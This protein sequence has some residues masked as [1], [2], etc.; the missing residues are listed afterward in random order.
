MGLKFD[1]KD[2]AS[3]DRR[4][5]HQRR[6]L[7]ETWERRSSTMRGRLYKGVLAGLC[8]CLFGALLI[9]SRYTSPKSG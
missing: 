7:Q 3:T 5:E 9:R 4:I 6:L 2:A 8:L 1:W